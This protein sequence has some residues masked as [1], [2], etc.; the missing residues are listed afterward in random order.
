MF[1]PLPPPLHQPFYCNYLKNLN[2]FIL[3]DI[4]DFHLVFG[5]TAVLNNVEHEI[6]Y[7]QF[8]TIHSVLVLGL[9]GLEEWTALVIITN[10]S[11]MMQVHI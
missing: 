7:C 5:L 11:R 8:N 6:S 4:I 10:R 3:E 1:Y 2:L 9:V